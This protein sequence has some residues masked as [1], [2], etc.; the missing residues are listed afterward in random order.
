MKEKLIKNDP[1][2][3]VKLVYNDETIYIT[4]DILKKYKL[5]NLNDISLETFI[6]IK[7]EIYINELYLKCIKKISNRL[8]SEKEIRDYLSKYTSYDN[9]VVIVNRLKE[10]NY[11]NDLV[12]TDSYIH[13]RLK[14]SNY[15]PKVITNELIL[16]GINKETIDMHMPAFN[17]ELFISKINS[18]IDKN[19]SLNKPVDITRK[20]LNMGYDIEVIK[21]VTNK[22]SH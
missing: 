22:K 20:L 21:L 9:V 1:N 12:Y 15:G 7:N 8:K 17:D 11:I 18:I 6:L 4:N 16:K 2:Y 19:N 13:D 14:F 10:N 3:K 5:Y